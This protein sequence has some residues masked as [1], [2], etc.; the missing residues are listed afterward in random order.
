[1]IDNCICF[2]T[3]SG[4]VTGAYRINNAANTNKKT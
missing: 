4:I 1:L 2:L 3:W